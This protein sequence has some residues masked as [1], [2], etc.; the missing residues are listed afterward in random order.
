MESNHIPVNTGLINALPIFT[1]SNVHVYSVIKR[2][3]A[4]SAFTLFEYIACVTQ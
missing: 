4:T 1:V 2:V 3:K